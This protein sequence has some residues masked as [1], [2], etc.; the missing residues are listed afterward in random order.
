MIVL[1]AIALVFWYRAQSSERARRRSEKRFEHFASAAYDW[2]WETDATLQLTYISNCRANQGVI[3]IDNLIGKFRW[4]ATT[5]DIENEKW[6]TH[7][8]CME[9]HLP[10][11]NFEYNSLTMDGR[12][13]VISTSGM[14][15]FDKHG[16][17]LGYRGAAT[18]VTHLIEARE[19]ESKRAERL[20]AILEACPFSAIVSNYVT[21]EV[22]FTNAAA[23]RLFRGAESSMVGKR[24]LY[25]WAD[26]QDRADA[27]Y[28]FQRT[29][30]VAPRQVQLKRLDGDVFWALMAWE[31]VE[32][33]G[34]DAIIA[35]HYDV[36][37]QKTAADALQVAK[38]EAE[39]A[40]NAKSEFLS[41][42]SH[43]LR[44]PLNAILGFAQILESDLSDDTP[45][46]Q[47]RSIRQILDSTQHLMRL[48]NQLLELNRIDNA[49]LPVVREDF[50]LNDV[51]EECLLIAGNEARRKSISVFDSTDPSLVLNSDRT[52]V[53]Q[54]LLNLMTNAIKYNT[55]NGQVIIG[56]ECVGGRMRISIADTGIGIPEDRQDAVF[57][58]FERLGREH[59]TVE[60]TGIGLAIS[61]RLIES[62]D[63]EIGFES[64]PG[65]GST[66]WI[67]LPYEGKTPNA[68]TSTNV[69]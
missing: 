53:L 4:D 7:R 46:R 63:G 18:D 67:D 3:D 21:R 57:V 10:F 66:F 36:S 33:F 45:A 30:R 11:S 25:L 16:V 8:Q 34:P 61:R 58:P 27:I 19:A 14:P 29:R 20:R 28:E 5:E 15:L 12:R 6:R 51:I 32:P 2:F 37:D 52:R 44:T 23:Q 39:T 59:G 49:D 69:N 17:F 56:Q 48:V 1:A 13:K 55:E 64:A 26:E 31:R 54:S 35:W 65:L 62:V 47:Q 42:M 43:E 60:G 9:Q 41:S 68:Q 24:G 50:A 40:S 38:E 22:I